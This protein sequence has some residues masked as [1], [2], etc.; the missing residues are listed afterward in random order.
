MLLMLVAPVVMAWYYYGTSVFRTV[1]VSVLTAALLEFITGLMSKRMGTLKDLNAVFTGALIALMLP[2]NSSPLL[3]AA[4]SAFAILIA[5][6]PFGGTRTAPFMPAAAGVAFICLCRPQAVF[7]YPPV[8][9]VSQNT[10]GTGVSLASMLKLNQSVSL[11]VISFFNVF[12]GN[13]A[14]PVGATCTMVLIG[15]AVFLAIRQP[16]SAINSAGFLLGS[17]IMA[18]LFP[19]VLNGILTSLVFELCSGMLI[20]TALFLITDPATS[21]RRPLSRFLYGMFAGILC[22]VMRY[23]GVF[24]EGAFFAVLISSAVWPLI[25]AWIKRTVRYIDKKRSRKATMGREMINER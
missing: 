17:A 14:G 10:V 8:G 16:K 22:M 18:M 12:I 6:M 15:A 23:F 20:F 3:A 2:A 5:K 9:F 13:I 7:T 25:T 19:R 4:G 21:P 24:E 11:N 1:I